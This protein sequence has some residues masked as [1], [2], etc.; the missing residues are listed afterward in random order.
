MKVSGILETVIYTDQLKA[1]EEF[2]TAILGLKFVS[3]EENKF[4]F[5][6][7]RHRMLL[8]FNPQATATQTHLPKH[9]AHGPQHVAFAVPGAELDQWHKVLID[10]GVIIE[11]DM[12]WENG[13]RSLYFR[14]P[15]D[16]SVELASPIIWNL[17]EN[18]P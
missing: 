7:C 15:A 9:G 8:I 16:N 11:Q 2:Y 18:L 13:S 14:D 12:Q 17:P 10:H 3:R 5:L 6:Q 4:V 1:C